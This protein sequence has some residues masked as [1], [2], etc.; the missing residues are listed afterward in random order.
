MTTR[1]VP[2]VDTWEEPRYLRR[3]SESRRTVEIKL[4]GHAVVRGWIEYF[5]R[6]FVRLT[7]DEG[8]NL[9]IYKHEIMYIA[10]MPERRRHSRNEAS[11]GPQSPVDSSGAQRAENQSEDARPRSGKAD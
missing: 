3:L 8:P 7:C 6:D 2:T 4:R 5:D 1:N 9:F 10:E 11:A